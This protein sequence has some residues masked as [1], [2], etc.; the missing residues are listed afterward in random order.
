[1]AE[2]GTHSA[3]ERA[4]L[5]TLR[6]NVGVP[7]F[8]PDPTGKESCESILASS[9]AGGAARRCLKRRQRYQWVG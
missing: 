9:L 2:L 3:T 7:Q 6:L 4:G 8:Y 5:E 1:M